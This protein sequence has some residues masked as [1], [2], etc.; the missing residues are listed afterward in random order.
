M[1]KMPKK[2]P[3]IDVWRF[4]ESRWHSKYVCRFCLHSVLIQN[5]PQWDDNRD[6]WI[7]A[8]CRP[9]K[10]FLNKD[11]YVQHHFIVHD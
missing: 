7:C 3:R 6:F 8:H 1:Y 5:N 11:E 2:Y 4:K 10:K 9:P